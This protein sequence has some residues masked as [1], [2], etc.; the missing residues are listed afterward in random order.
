VKRRRGAKLMAGA[1]MA[2][3]GIVLLPLLSPPFTHVLAVI[4]LIPFLAGFLID[5]QMV[6]GHE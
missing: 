4:V 5:W 3:L 2:F 1:Q 6:C